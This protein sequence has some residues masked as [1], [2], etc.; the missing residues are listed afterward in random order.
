MGTH[1]GRVRALISDKGKR[2]TEVLPGTPV[3]IQGLNGV[4]GAGQKFAV[5]S[6]ERTARQIAMHRLEKEREKVV[7]RP[8]FSLEELHRRVEEGELKELNIV[9]K[10]DVQGSLEALQFSLNKLSGEKVK[11]NVI[12]AGVGG[13]SESDVM[14]ASAS[15]A[16]IIGFNVRPELKGADLAERERVDI[17]LYSVIYDVVEDIRKAMEGMLEPSFREMPVGRAEVRNTFHIS[18]LGTVAGCYVLS[19]KVTRN[20]SVRLLRDNVVIY[21]GKL[22]SLKRFKDDTREVVEGYECG[23]GLENFNDIKVGDQIEAFVME[24]VVETLS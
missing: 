8:R 3:E 22:A 10:T 12:H 11:V 13:I 1:Y 21:E 6:D 5:L 17:R 2:L 4:P 14:L 9:L 24:K 16:V 23:L 19:G 18:R 15:T 20:A 7:A